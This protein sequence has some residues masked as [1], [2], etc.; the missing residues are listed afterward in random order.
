MPPLKKQKKM[1]TTPLSITKLVKHRL[2]LPEGL[3]PG[4]VCSSR[5][6]VAV[7]GRRQQR[8]G[9]RRRSRAPLVVRVPTV[10]RLRLPAGAA[11]PGR[12]PVPDIPGQRRLRLPG[13]RAAGSS[14]GLPGRA[15]QGGRVHPR[16][17]APGTVRHCLE[18]DE[19]RSLL[20]GV[21]DLQAAGEMV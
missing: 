10:L 9:L 2:E 1:D 5:V 3:S 20:G 13:R 8:W 7:G 16:G 11:Q 12:H 4:A 21:A 14:A 6:A 15:R 18:E 17:G 19:R